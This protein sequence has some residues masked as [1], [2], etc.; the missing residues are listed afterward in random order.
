MGVAVTIDGAETRNISS[1]DVLKLDGKA[2]GLSF[3]CSVCTPVQREV[4]AGDKDETLVV[5]VPIKPATLDI[6]GPVDRTYQIVEHPEIRV[7]AGIN[8]IPLRS[9]LENVTVKQIDSNATV[10]VQL[11]AGG[12]P[13]TASF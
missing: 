12:K 4:A 5:K 2:H 7:R 3:T 9:A 13:K 11:E 8:T 6:E 1:G 10:R